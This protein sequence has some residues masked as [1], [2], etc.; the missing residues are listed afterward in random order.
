MPYHLFDLT[1]VQLTVRQQENALQSKSFISKISWVCLLITAGIL[2]SACPGKGPEASTNTGPAKAPRTPSKATFLAVGDMMIS[3]GVARVID[4]ARD[5]LIPF[6][7][8]EKEFLATDF[9]FGN[10]ESPVSGNDNRVGK[11]LVF[12]ARKADIEGLVKYK[13]KVVNLANN[14]ALDQGPNGLQFTRDFLTQKGIEYLG[15]G[16]DLNEAWKPKFVEAN[17]IKI[18]FVGASYASIND[19]GVARNNLVARVEDEENLKKAI[20]SARSQSDFVVVTMHAGIEYVRQPDKT[21]VKFARA[22]VDF[23]ADVVIGAH[24]HWVQVTEEYKGKMIYYS[25][26]N[27]IFDQRKPETI[28]GLMLKVNL[29]TSANP[30]ERATLDSIEYM[31]VVIEK[32]GIPRLATPTEAKSILQKINITD[33]IYRPAA[34]ATAK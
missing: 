24:P 23:G 8:L 19:G 34:A 20:E 18:G 2:I 30:D 6:S 31:P 15:V 14:H 11:G 7:A 16:A 13:F 12:N 9:N 17:G 4:S 3:R 25:L 21:Q 26:G 29:K 22:A 33:P 1:Q 5:P 28:L 32:M 10:L 27:F